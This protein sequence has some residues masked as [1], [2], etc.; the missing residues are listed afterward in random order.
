M[1]SGQKVKMKVPGVGK[2]DSLQE[3][4][5]PVEYERTRF[6]CLLMGGLVYLNHL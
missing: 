1:M 3:G 2:C 6:S 5:C 4:H